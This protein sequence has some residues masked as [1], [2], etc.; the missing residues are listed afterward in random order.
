[1]IK[2]LLFLLP[3]SAFGAAPVLFYTDLTSGPNTGGESNNGVNVCLFGRNFG[4]SRGT[5]TITLNGA[6]V[7]AYKSWQSGVAGGDRADDKACVQLGSGTSTGNFVLTTTGGTSNGLPF[8]VRSGN[9]YYVATTGSD[10]AAGTFAAPWLTLTHARDT[11][12][13]GGTVYA[14]TGSYLT[15]DDGSGYSTCM[16]IRATGG[17]AGAP[18]AMLA[19]P[20]QTV[21]LGDTNNCTYTIRTQGSGEYYWVFADFAQIIGNQITFGTYGVHD[22]RIVGNANM[23]CPNGNGASGCLDMTG[24][25]DGSEYNYYIYGNYINHAGTNLSPG[26]VTALYHGVYLSQQV[27]SVYF[28]WN[29]IAFIQGCR[30]LQQNVNDNNSTDRAGSYDLHIF[31][32]VIHDTQCD[33][34]V[35]TTINP[36]AGTVEVYENVIYNAGQGPANSDNTGAWFCINL[37][38]YSNAGVTGESGS[39]LVY[40]N[41]LYNCGS[42]SSPPYTGANGGLLWEDGNTSTKGMVLKNN[43]I[44]PVSFPTSTYFQY[45]WVYN[46]GGGTCTSSCSQVTGSNNLWYNDGSSPTNNVLTANVN[47]NPLLTNPGSAVFTLQSGS[48][49]ATGG[50]TTSQTQDFIG[51]SLPQGANYPI[52]AY[53]LPVGGLTPPVGLTANIAMTSGVTAR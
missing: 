5:S 16:L 19:Y 47:S 38:G 31:D 4:S 51:V 26:S 35:M 13:A 6:A 30:G 12:A 37:Q 15:M 34:I 44:Y 42:Y 24:G 3:L 33:G 20:G 53:A 49:A 7:A 39:A 9:I 28:G 45:L 23:T 40:S 36:S 21:N 43:I 2:T 14:E 29:T 52:G 18:N 17:S 11:M 50:A 8:T 10:S 27:H 25:L 1:M 41:T 46:N 22:W 48:P 32:N